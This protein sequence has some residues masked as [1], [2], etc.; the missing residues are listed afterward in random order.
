MSIH[1]F[2][3]HLV[4][5]TARREN[6]QR[7]F[8]TCQN[9]TG[10]NLTAEIWPAVDGAE[11]SLTDL[12]EIV[13]AQLMEPA[14]PFG[15]RAGEIGCFLSHRQIWA[16]LLM[17]EDSAALIIEDDAE[18]ETSL[19]AEALT[20]AKT[21]IQN[22]GYIQFQTRAPKGTAFLVDTFGEARLVIPQVAQLRTTAQMISREAAAHLLEH[23][24]L[25]DRPVDTFMQSHWHTGLRPAMIYPSGVRD[26]SHDL[27]GSTIQGHDHRPM[28]KLMREIRRMR[29]RSSVKRLSRNSFAP[30]QGGFLDEH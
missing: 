26:V 29:F 23:S 30:E 12:D 19:F 20:L 6:A 1:T 27:D 3:L 25:I 14:Y 10:P 8:A 24:N 11:M 18:L 4:R 22:L 21:H 2:V 16:E 17:R 13:G 7:L 15:L 9:E 28:E 5:A